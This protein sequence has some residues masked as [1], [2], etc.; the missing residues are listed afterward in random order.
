MDDTPRR[1]PNLDVYGHVLPTPEEGLVEAKRLLART[2]RRGERVWLLGTRYDP[3]GPGWLIDIVRQGAAGRW[4]RQ[5]YMFD[6]AAQV[7]HYRGESTLDDA[8]FRA[9]RREGSIFS[10]AEWQDQTA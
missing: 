2:F 3:I 10:I 7:L 6:E 5:R 1:L 9:A 4:V 8:E